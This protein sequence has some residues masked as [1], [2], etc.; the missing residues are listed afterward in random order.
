MRRSI[1]CPT[2]P[3]WSWP[4][5][6]DFGQKNLPGGG[7]RGNFYAKKLPKYSVFLVKICYFTKNLCPGVRNLGKIFARAW[8]IW[9]K[10]LARG[11]PIPTP[12]RG[13]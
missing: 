1:L 13:I 8:G 9:P 2:Y 5:G 12:N 4:G 11:Y 3:P 10:I 6:G 7:G